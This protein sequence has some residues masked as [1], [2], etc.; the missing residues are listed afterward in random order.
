MPKKRT[1]ADYPPC[2]ISDRISEL[3]QESGMAL[4]EF[5]KVCGFTGYFPNCRTVMAMLSTFSLPS[6][7][8]IRNLCIR[9]GVTG[10]WLLGLTDE[11]N[12]KN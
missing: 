8:G 9:F 7:Y 4:S 11:K 5:A 2:I 3:F 10:D 12:P 1:R 6:P